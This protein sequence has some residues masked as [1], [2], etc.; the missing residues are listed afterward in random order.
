MTMQRARPL[1]IGVA[2]GSGSGKSTLTARIAGALQGFSVVIIP[3]DRYFRRVKPKMVAPFT[4]L[5][6][7]DH[8]HPDSFDLDALVRDL[9]T[10][11]QQNQAEVV[12]IEGLMTL[13]DLDIRSRLDLKI[14]L[15]VQAD[16]RIVRRLRRNMAHGLQFDDIAAFYL[17]SV[18]Y[19]HQEFVE[20]SRWHAD[21][22]LNGSIVSDRGLDLVT[23]WVRSHAPHLGQEGA[24]CLTSKS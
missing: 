6:Y 2:G 21:I 10:L 5:T 7:E 17:D 4:G 9:D 11:L 18:R 24:P 16:E 14:Y 15:D 12:I 19:R 22:V 23:E 3:M 13:H 8:N 1:V 20:P